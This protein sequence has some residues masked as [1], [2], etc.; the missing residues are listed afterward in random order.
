MPFFSL[1]PMS[2]YISY[3][4]LSNLHLAFINSVL[5]CSEPLNFHEAKKS[6]EWCDA[7]DVEFSS[8]EGLDTWDIC[9]LLEGKDTIGCK[10]IFKLKLHSDGSLERH[11]A[12]L[13][14][15]GY[16]QHEGIDY[17]DTF[18][19]IAKMVTIKLLLALSAKKKWFLHHLDISNAFL[20]GDLSEEI[21]MDLPPGYADRKGDSLSPYSVLKLKKSIYGLKQTSRQWFLKVSLALH[22]LGFQLINGDHSLFLS[23]LPDAVLVVLV[24]V[25][26]ILI[27][28]DNDDA[29]S[30]FI[31]QLKAYFKLRDLGQ[32]KYFLGLEIARLICSNLL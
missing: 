27:A 3:N 25:D 12:R 6:K 5:L 10:W 24:Y 8:L 28:S 23:L 26:D 17:V 30:R 1:Y 11:K 22:A 9:Q 15:K 16:T 19:P 13:V 14:A 2:A 29:I 18:S 4:K 21:Y 32:L 7:V 31:S 20:N